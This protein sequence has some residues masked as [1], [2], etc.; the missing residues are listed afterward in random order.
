[1]LA[2]LLL[3]AYLLLYIN[4]PSSADGQALLAVADTLVEHGRFDINV[5]GYTEWLLTEDGRMGSFGV[6]GA[7]YS[8]KGLTPSLA[9]LPLVALAHLV[10]GPGTRATAMLMNPLVTTFSALL[11]AYFAR[12][13]G[14]RDRTAFAL[15]LMYGL[16]T[17]AAVYV[18]TLFGEPLAA[19]LLLATVIC[20]HTADSR[21]TPLRIAG[22]CLGLLAGINT[23]YVLFIPIIAWY[24]FWRRPINPRAWINFAL[25]VTFALALLALYNWTRFGS[26]LESGYHFDS[27]EGFNNP[28]LIGLYGLFFSPYR[29]IFW[30]SPVLLLAIPGWLMF[31]RQQPGLGWLIVGLVVLQALAF[32]G[33]WSWHGGI[34]WGPRFLLPVLPLATLLLA[35]L[36]EAAFQKRGLAL[37]LVG[38]SVLSLLVQILGTAVSYLYY[39]KLLRDWFYPDFTTANQILRTSPVMFNPAYSPILGHLALL[40]TGW[41][42]EPAWLQNG[43]AV[44]YPLAAFAIIGAGVLQAVLRPRIVRV[45]AI[46]MIAAAL[47]LIVSRQQAAPEQADTAA[48]S[49]ALQ[50]PGTIVVASLLLDDRLLDVNSGASIISMNAPTHPDDP[51]AQAMWHYALHQP[52]PFWF[53]S[54]FGPADPLNW[55]VRDLWQ[56]AYFVRETQA[57]QHHAL[58]FDR[59]PD[60]EADTPGG[61]RFGPI[62]LDAYRITRDADGVRIRLQ[63]STADPNTRS[64]YTWFVHLI[65]TSGNI[66][67]QQD[68]PPQGGYA[69]TSGWQ[70]DTP[71]TDRL[72]FPLPAAMDTTG[73]QVRVGWLEHGERLPAFTPEKEVIEE[74]Y[75]LLPILP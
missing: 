40:R 73:W 24:R 60:P 26:P 62:L 74:G 32:A 46:L 58:H 41:P 42:L 72:L 59:T 65:D 29:G 5:I 61:W 63:W 52:D 18:Q 33:W 3:G 7:L 39:D 22:L 68:R 30:Y 13:L 35:P 25:P 44:I 8:K 48:L 64:D 9:V 45:F 36:I 12:R 2:A 23:A 71:V 10:P 19:L 28:L 66:I 31:R 56:S 27:G 17:L 16:A 54:W 67:A 47:L 43:V 15:G 21:I 69:P 51:R 37:V 53:V 50:P 11:L 1:M 6:D 70:P 49:Q 38:F 14:Y 4:A 55:Q 20:V 75:A 57:V 34:V